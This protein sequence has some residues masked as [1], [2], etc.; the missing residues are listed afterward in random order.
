LLRCIL[1][2]V[3]IA[4]LV[5]QFTD[6]NHFSTYKVSLES[7][8]LIPLGACFS[9]GA[10]LA[11]LPK[12]WTQHA[13]ARMITVVA[14]GLIIIATMYWGGF[15]KAQYVILPVFVIALGISNYSALSW[16][17]RYGDISYGVYIWGFIVQQLLWYFFQPSQ[18]IML[19]LSIPI[20]WALGFASW[21]LVEERALRLKLNLP[22]TAVAA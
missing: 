16:I 22:H 17:R 10:I 3:F 4:L 8:Q 6:N 20:T 12:E 15:T 19:L 21:H 11:L 5:L 18:P 1:L 14:S 13:Q 9:A 2:V 7:E